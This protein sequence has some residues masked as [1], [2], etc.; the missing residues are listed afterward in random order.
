LSRWFRHYAGMS[1]DD[2]LVRAAVK[3]RQ[4]VERAVW[5][6]G[7]IL[8]TAAEINDAG[9]YD[10]DVDEAAYFLRCE[11]SDLSSILDALRD[12]GR[13][14]SGKVTK[15]G[16]RQF[17]SDG[18][19]ERQQRYRDRQKASQERNGDVTPS[20]RDGEVTPQETETQT[21][22][23]TPP[24]SVPDAAE[25][26]DLFG[27]VWEAFPQNPSSSETKARKAFERI[28]DADR[29]AVVAA[30]ER[31]ARWFAQDCEQRGRTVD[32]GLHYV[33]HLG[34]WLDSGEWRDAASLPVKGEAD[35]SLAS[36]HRDSDD[37]KALERFRGKPIKV[38]SDN[39]MI[40]VPIAELN[41]ARAGALN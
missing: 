27:E 21:E 1:R 5:V 8:E 37:F 39:G 18:S 28:K 29:P 38:F 30:A 17:E 13:I 23:E 34:K 32:A 12:L 3:A 20:S 15:W 40:T 25:A 36:V 31:Y 24:S 7:A 41:Q 4:P 33:P 22:T 35:P 6:Y 26:R 2:K 19:K 16:D 14:D 10:F 11:P 9:R